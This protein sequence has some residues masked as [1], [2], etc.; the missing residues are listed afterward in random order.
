MHVLVRAKQ[1]R[2][3]LEQGDWLE[4]VRETPLRYT[5]Y[6]AVSHRAE[7]KIAP[8]LARKRQKQRDA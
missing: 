7:P 1:G 3:T 4:A 2:S 6:V 8:K 5:D